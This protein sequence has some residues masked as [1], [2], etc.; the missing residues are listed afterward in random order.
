MGF[1][2]HL[3]PALRRHEHIVSE[4]HLRLVQNDAIGVDEHIVAHLDVRPIVAEERRIDD[5]ILPDLADEFPKERL[6]PLEIGN[7][8]SIVILTHLLRPVKLV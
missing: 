3:K 1:D 8:E 2:S 5:Q 6:P 4:R 7:P